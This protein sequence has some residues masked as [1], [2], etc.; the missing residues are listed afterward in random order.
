MVQR[1]HMQ[2]RMWSRGQPGNEANPEQHNVN[3]PTMC[4]HCIALLLNTPKKLQQVTRKEVCPYEI[5]QQMISYHKFCSKHGCSLVSSLADVAVSLA[6]GL[7]KV[8]GQ[9]SSMGWR[10]V[11]RMGRPS[12]PPSR[13]TCLSSRRP[14]LIGHA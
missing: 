1:S 4:R 13:D 5:Y 3:W 2:S 14:L 11:K 12:L 10:R 6:A 7:R 9:K 8:V